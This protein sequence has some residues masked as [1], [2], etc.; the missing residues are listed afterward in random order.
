MEGS[1]S[2]SGA[3]PAGSS[4]TMLI[5]IIIVVIVIVA[6]VAAVLL[7]N[8]DNPTPEPTNYLEKGFKMQIYYNSGNTARQAAAEILKTK[9]ESLN[10]GKILITVTG[11][12]WAQYLKLQRGSNMPAFFL[13]WAP[14]YAD[15]NDYVVPFLASQGTYL[16]TIG[17]SNATLDAMITTAGSNPDPVTR[18]QQYKQITLDVQ[19]ECL[20]VWVSQ[21]AVLYVSQSGISGYHFNPLYSN[22][23]YYDLNKT[24]GTPG[25]PTDT[26][27]YG[28]IAGNPD[29]FDP[30]RDYETAGGEVLQNVYETLIWYQ[31]DR[32]DVL[33]PQ[34]CTELPSVANGGITNSDKDYTYHVRPGVTFQDGSALDAYDV[35]FSIERLLRLNDVNGPAWMYGETLIPDYYNSQ[36]AP[37]HYVG[38]IDNYTT[39][40]EFN[41][42]TGVMTGGIQNASALKGAMWVKDPMTIQFNLTI[43]NPAWNSILAFNGGSI[44]SLKNVFAHLSASNINVFSKEAYDWVNG[45]PV[46]TGPYEFIQ[47][48]P[49]QYVS[50]KRYD[51]YWR[52]PADIKNVLLQQIADTTSRINQLIA[53]DLD[54]AAVP[55]ASQ[56]AVF[57]KGLNIVNSSNWNVNFLGL[58]QDIDITGRN[59]DLNDIPSDFFADLRVR[60]AFAHA[61]DFQTF[62][63]TTMRGVAIQ[64]NGVIPKGMFGYHADIPQYAF[65]LT[66]AAALLKS[67]TVPTSSSTARISVEFVARID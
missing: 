57:G 14:D 25:N 18:D 21:A 61:W 13:G 1:S 63:V 49:S 24:G 12:E 28:E 66:Q 54:A 29:Y 62:N 60:Q 16:H 50:M 67:V 35:K 7:T 51:N 56:Q 65:N 38:S 48:A 59:Q 34:L 39:P 46:G 5:A 58:N 4:R 30:A 22:L 26:F 43:A 31:S 32:S 11:I 23:Y 27:T 53:G 9:L 15:P 6:A 10:P 36:Y 2:A 33:I 42:A 45:H 52:G 17:Y 47:F 41:N 3:K 19:K 55:R 8:N 20:Y 44:V 37:S 64:P 40:F